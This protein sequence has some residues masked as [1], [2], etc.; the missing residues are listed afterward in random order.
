MSPSRRGGN[1]RT[2]LHDPAA[3]SGAR[4]S[5]DLIRNPFPYMFIMLAVPSR[6]GVHVRVCVCSRVRVYVCA[7]VRV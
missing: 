5:D 4:M 3:R 1:A 7:F 6:I 2:P